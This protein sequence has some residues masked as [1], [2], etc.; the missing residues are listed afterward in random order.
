MRGRKLR[1]LLV[2]SSLA[3]AICVFLTGVGLAGQEVEFSSPGLPPS[4]MDAAGRLVEDWGTVELQVEGADLAE[5]SPKVVPIMLD[6]C[7]PAALAEADRG[8]LRV[9]WIAYRAPIFPS[10]VDVLTVRLQATGSEAVPALVKVQLSAEA[11]ATL[12]T[13][14]IGNRVVLSVPLETFAHVQ[15]RDW[16]Y[17]NETTAMPGWAKPEGPADPAYANIRAGMGG[18]PILY[19]FKVEPGSQAVVILGICESHYD[20]AGIRPVLYEVEGA[21]P[22]VVNPIARW[23]RHR[24]GALPFRARDVNG[25]GQLEVAARPLPNA[26]DRNPILNV[27]WVFQGNRAPSLPRLISGELSHTAW[28]YVDVGGQNDQSFYLG[29]PLQFPVIVPASGSCELSFLV[30]CQG[31]SAPVPESTAWTPSS[32]RQAAREVWLAWS[33]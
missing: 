26:R 1:A 18:V 17:V 22:E 29:E 20:R 28:R 33:R 30:A 16:G 9:T 11:K 19:R 27:I 3:W 5:A 12:T 6:D 4:K 8:P 32:L 15:T 13:A 21:R 14:R 31:S 25:D 10:G 2:G 7:I 23:G 24:P